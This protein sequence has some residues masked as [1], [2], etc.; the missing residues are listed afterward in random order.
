MI[1]RASH[2]LLVITLILIGNDLKAQFYR[3]AADT[4][5]LGHKMVSPFMMGIKLIIFCIKRMIARLLQGI[6]FQAYLK[7]LPNK[8]G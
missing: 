6:S 2:T 1:S 5:G 7:I 3:I 8:F 4:C